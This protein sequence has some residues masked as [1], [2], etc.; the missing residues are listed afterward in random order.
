MLALHSV[1]RTCRVWLRASLNVCFG[2]VS[3]V[4]VS[5]EAELHDEGVRK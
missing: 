2:A 5:A 1:E 3:R 4:S